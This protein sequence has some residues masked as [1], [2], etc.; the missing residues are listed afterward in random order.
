[1]PFVRAILQALLTLQLLL[2]LPALA[3]LASTSPWK[4]TND[5]DFL[6]LYQGTGT[7]ATAVSPEILLVLDQ[8]G[9]TSR[10]MFHPLFP[11]NWQDENQPNSPAATESVDYTILISN[12]SWPSSGSLD[13][14]LQVG[15]ANDYSQT[16]FSSVTSGRTTTNYTIQASG[17]RYTIGGARATVT[18]GSYTYAY[19]TLIKPDGTEVTAA[20]VTAS[21]GRLS[22]AVAWMKC[23]SH[24]RLQLSAIDGTA[25]SPLRV[26]DFPLFYKPI[27]AGATISTASGLT[28]GTGTAIGGLS[29]DLATDPLHTSTPVQVDSDLSTTT[30]AMDSTSASATVNLFGGYPNTNPVCAVRSRYIEWVFVGKDPASPG[31][32]YYCIPNAIPSNTSDKSVQN[33][34]DPASVSWDGPTDTYSWT[35]ITSATTGIDLSKGWYPAFTN[36]LPNRTRMQAIKESVI[37]SYLN[38]QSSIFCAWRQLADTGTT[39]SNNLAAGDGSDWNYITGAADLANIAAI[40]PGGGTPMV[41]TFLNAYCQMTNPAAFQ[42]M[43]AAK[44]YSAG[45]IECL[46]HFIIFCTDGAPSS[47]A[48]GGG[49]R[50]GPAWSAEGGCSFPYA[51]S[52]VPAG[53][54][55]YTAQTSATYSGNAAV[56]ANPAYIDGT[57]QYFFNPPTLAGIAAHGGDGSTTN[58][59]WI[60]DPLQEGLSGNLDD[61]TNGNG[62][63]PFWVKGRRLTTGTTVTSFAHAQPI[64]TF[65]V[66][67]SLGVDYLTSTGADW[68]TTTN[69]APT[70]GTTRKLIQ[71]DV[72]GSKYRLMMAALFGDPADSSWDVTNTSPFYVDPTTNQIAGDSS[73]FF[74]GRDP[75]TLVNHLNIAINDAVKLSG[76]SSTAAPVFPN[77]GAGLGNSVYIAKFEPPT[78]PG[79]LW[80]GD[81]TMFPTK[82]TAAGTILIDSTGAAITGSLDAATPQWSAATALNTRGWLN[83]V[84]YSRPPSP[85]ATGWN[86]A[87]VQVNLGT[88]GTGTSNAGYTA[89]STWLP[90]SNAANKLK[91][92]QFLVG[93]DVSSGTAPLGTR[94]DTIMGDIINSAPSVLQY[95]DLP[96]SVRSFSSTLATAW[97]AHKPVSGSSDQTGSFRVIFVG[98]N[99][100]LF[101]AFGEVDWVD[102]TTNS[103]TPITRGV[104]DELWAFVPTEI[105]PNIDQLQVSTN[106]HSYAVDGQPTVYLLDL[107]QS[108]SQAA[109]NGIFDV[110]ST[111]AYAE[112][113]V[114][115]FGLGKGGRS[116]YAIDIADPCN[117][118]MKW[119]LCPNEQYNAPAARV[120]SGSATWIP[121][122]GLATTLPTLARVYT[123]LE[124]T[125]N[126]VV[127]AVLLGGGFSDPLVEAALPTTAVTTSLIANMPAKSTALGRGALALDINTGNILHIWDTSGTSGAGPVPAGVVPVEIDPGSGLTT[128]GY[129]TDYYGSLWGLGGTAMDVSPRT[130]FRLDTTSMDSWGVRQVY[131]QQVSVTGGSGNGL[132]TTLPAPF[133]LSSFP[134][135]RTTAPLE[136]PFAV[137]VAFNTGDRNNPLDS[138]TYTKWAA[139]TQHRLNVVFDRQDINSVLTDTTALTTATGIDADPTSSTYFLK[140]YYGYY[141]N[142]AA[143]AGGF[144]PKGIT[145]PLLLDYNI[146]YSYFNPTTASCAGGT[147]TTSTYQVCKVLVPI[148]NASAAAT[149]TAVNGCKSG[150]VLAW[151]GV[152]S[153]LAARNIVSGVQAGLTSG[154]GTT[155]DTTSVQNLTLQNLNTQS[156]DRYPKIR[157][158][159]I[160]H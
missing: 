59:K 51:Q 29:V 88:A 11:N 28:T 93:A 65:T 123:S 141:I 100:G 60:R 77:V 120:L 67:V 144:I 128:R 64:Q 156:S 116:Y 53:C 38:N 4:P 131:V 159:R 26:V 117:P 61:L 132:C 49:G 94:S 115:I 13:S 110:G 142:F 69:G 113:A 20:D 72:S 3:Q 78:N 133:L 104:V 153:S 137:G 126:Q 17:H 138:F 154:S 9:S 12:S 150:L 82:Q 32:A 111:G 135:T 1:M 125:T 129:F 96:S 145:A 30:P 152:A 44:G 47:I 146:F 80:T 2:G 33:A 139:P 15:F 79:P 151:T 99:Q 14:H 83:R 57:T 22:N 102:T 122:M 81:L 71:N 84:I 68:V 35:Y 157:I 87:M 140:T 36:K 158:W 10:L 160:L 155:D 114:V 52:S 48:S 75:T 24:L 18:I 34:I 58:T 98:T 50:S 97:D 56:K 130:M 73:Y 106:K 147:G 7:A 63:L 74:D 92:W 127:D 148:A 105:L 23:A 136:S 107:P 95:S 31:G 90:G 54:S 25:V 39:P 43:I 112:R 41:E 42:S 5:T 62:W 21:G 149:A 8:S 27:D 55:G 37:K 121:K 16:T 143:P 45:Q 119:A 70:V 101:H 40:S 19:N 76:V 6:N 66:G 46:K 118:A 91:N 85:T 124:G 103:T 108:S 86:N 109:G 89:I 134:V